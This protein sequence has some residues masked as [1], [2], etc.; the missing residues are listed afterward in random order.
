V[1]ELE[2]TSDDARL[3]VD[4]KYKVR[5]TQELTAATFTRSTVS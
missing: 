2:V 3:R 1:Q 5:R 4:L